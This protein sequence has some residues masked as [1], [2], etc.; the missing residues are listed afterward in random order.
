VRGLE[1][2]GVFGVPWELEACGTLDAGPLVC[3]TT[4]R[5]VSAW[6]CVAGR[7]FGEIRAAELDFHDELEQAQR[8]AVARTTLYLISRP[9]CML[10][11]GCDAS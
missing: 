10:D 1:V 8:S 3:A 5:G 6:V 9:G 2:L 7:D 11:A 4:E